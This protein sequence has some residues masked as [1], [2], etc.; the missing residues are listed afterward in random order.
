MLCSGIEVVITGLTRN[1]V[2]RLLACS[3]DPLASLGFAEYLRFLKTEYLRFFY[4]FSTFF[5]ADSE[6]VLKLGNV[7]NIRC[8][9]IEVVITGLTRN[10]FVG[11]HTWVRIPPAAPAQ[12]FPPPFRFRLC[13]KLHY[14]GNFF[15]FR[16]RF[17]SLDSWPRGI[18]RGQKINFNCLLKKRRC[19][20][21]VFSFVLSLPSMRKET[22]AAG[23]WPAALVSLWPLPAALSS[24]LHTGPSCPGRSRSSPASP[25]SRTGRAY[26]AP[27]RRRPMWRCSGWPYT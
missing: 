11:N 21:R 16:P 24:S 19:A 17:A 18:A 3:S 1:R 9:G 15:A 8:S 6:L 20:P 23:R 4:A 14:G 10:Q 7:G 22:S 2:G 12:K 27:A 26:S 5:Y 13:R 25:P